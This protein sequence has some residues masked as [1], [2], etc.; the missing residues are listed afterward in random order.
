[1]LT[2]QVDLT[3]KAS[4]RVAPTYTPISHSGKD[5]L[6]FSFFL[7]RKEIEETLVKNVASPALHGMADQMN[8]T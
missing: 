4:N 7:S 5:F 1:V 8:W 6:A 3:R 2:I